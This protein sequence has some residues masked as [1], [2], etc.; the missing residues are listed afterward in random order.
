[1][2]VRSHLGVA[3]VLAAGLLHCGPD[4]EI[5]GKDGA[6]MVLVPEGEFQ[7]GG[8]AEDLAGRTGNSGYLNY[9]GERPVHRV[10][11]HAFHLGRYEVTNAQY[12]RFLE[13][14]QSTGDRGMDHPD[15]PAGLGHHQQYMNENLDDDTQPAVGLNWFDA[16]AY[17]KWTGARLPTEAEW[18]YAARGNDGVYRK[19]PW[20][21]E[22]PDADGVWR[23]DFAVEG[24][25]ELDGH[26]FT[27][28]VG[29]YPDGVSPFGLYDMAGNAD[30][31]VNDWLDWSYYRVTEGAEDPQG[32][33]TG[34]H[35]VIKGGSYGGDRYHIRIGT[36]LWGDREVRNPY[37]GVRCARDP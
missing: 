32:P 7:M 10:R 9:E 5:K 23:A 15:Q 11:L 16:Y 1:M 28:P 13:H 6:E 8:R 21:N 4:P 33:E 20:G 30:E 22:D 26:R 31:W 2:K 25:P 17:C 12:K 29:T 36:R 19:Y 18:E 14:I 27:S 3:I 34:K 35:K 37:Q 24:G